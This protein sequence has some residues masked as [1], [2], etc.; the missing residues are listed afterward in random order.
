MAAPRKLRL[1]DTVIYTGPQQHCGAYSYPAIVTLI[2]EGSCVHLTV[3]PPLAASR[4]ESAVS[5]R[6]DSG[7][8]ARRFWTWPQEGLGE[9]RS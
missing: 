7:E 9:A 5:H 4:G 3:L 2:L 8:G 6:G 1:G